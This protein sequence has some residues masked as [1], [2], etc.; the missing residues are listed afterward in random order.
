MVL[1]F[2]VVG[3]LRNIFWLIFLGRVYIVVYVQMFSVFFIFCKP[4]HK[5]IANVDIFIHNFLKLL[6]LKLHSLT[7][8]NNHLRQLIDQTKIQALLL[9]T[10]KPQNHLF[11]KII[12]TWIIFWFKRTYIT[13]PGCYLSYPILLP[14]CCI[15]FNKFI[16]VCIEQSTVLFKVSGAR[17]IV[18]GL[19]YVVT[20][21]WR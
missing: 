7:L 21:Y 19:L 1:F 17:S 15:S 18:L 5:L 6:L 8:Q 12:N 9:P 13:Y 3:T 20:D 16:G 4:K 2:L 14:L 10:L 11:I